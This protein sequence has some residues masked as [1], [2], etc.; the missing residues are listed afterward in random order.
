[1]EILNSMFAKLDPYRTRLEPRR[2]SAAPGR[3]EAAGQSAP[4]SSGDR[5]SLSAIARLLTVA[6]AEAGKAP[7]VRQE[8]VDSIK[9]RVASGEYAPDQ[10][11]TAKNLLRDEA[12]LAGSPRDEP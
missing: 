11:Q 5:V 2:E 4:P 12:L 8:K 7:D 3:G 6:H 9:E 10:E 1:M